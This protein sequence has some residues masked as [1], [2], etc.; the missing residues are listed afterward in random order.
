MH[1]FV[2]ISFTF[3]DLHFW[4]VLA[5]K[6]WE[7]GVAI[8]SCSGC[9]KYFWKNMSTR[10]TINNSFRNHDAEKAGMSR[11]NPQTNKYWLRFQLISPPP[12]LVQTGWRS[13][14]SAAVEKIELVLTF[15]LL[16]LLL[17][18]LL[19]LLLLA[20]YSCNTTMINISDSAL[21]PKCIPSD[22]LASGFAHFPIP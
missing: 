7:S 8:N 22:C 15:C 17:L 11:L 16:L 4:I 18:I 21:T 1:A 13:A 3:I 10:H 20:R 14:G 6:P 2:V 5:Q 9:E 19:L 12:R